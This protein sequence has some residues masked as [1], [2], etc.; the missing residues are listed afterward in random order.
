MGHRTLENPSAECPR[1]FIP[2]DGCPGTLISG[3]HPSLLPLQLGVTMGYQYYP[4]TTDDPQ[5]TTH[6]HHKKFTSTWFFKTGM[7]EI[8]WLTSLC[9]CRAQNQRF[10][11]HEGTWLEGGRLRREVGE[12]NNSVI[13]LCLLVT[14]ILL[15]CNNGR[16]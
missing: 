3:G 8:F 7:W 16:L 2:G 6:N 1:T 12:D 10:C 15:Y 5:P 9:T 11:Q 14:K 13:F 4:M